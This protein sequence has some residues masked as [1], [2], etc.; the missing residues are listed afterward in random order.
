MSGVMSFQHLFIQTHLSSED[1]KSMIFRSCISR[2]TDELIEGYID[3]DRY[4][5]DPT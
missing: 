2:I 5:I 3:Y 1:I 4:K